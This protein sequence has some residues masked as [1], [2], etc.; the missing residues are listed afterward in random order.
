M[1]RPQ[2]LA[3]PA[4][5]RAEIRATL[6]LAWPLILGNFAQAAINTT[7]VLILGRYDTDALAAS[8]LAVNLYFAFGVFAMGL[9]TAASP[10]IAAE[11]GRRFNSVRDVRRTVRQAL[12]ASITIC[13]PIWL[14]LWF[15]EPI[16][17]ALGQE[18]A[19]ADMAGHFLR[20][21][22]WGLLP[23][24]G[25]VVL[26]YYVSALER[27]IWG[28]I[29]TS[30]GVAFNALICWALVYGRLGLPEMGLTGAAV[31]NVCAYLFLL[32]GMVAVTRWVRPFRRYRLFGHFW[33]ADWPRYRE[34]FRLGLPI[35]ITLALEVT[36]FNAAVFLMGLIGRDEIAAHAV[37]IQI[38]SLAFMVPFGLSQAATV[39]VGLAHGRRDA[40]GVA[41]A[42]WVALGLGIGA[43]F[44][45]SSA[46]AL[47]PETVIGL[48]IDAADPVNARVFELAVSFLLVAAIFQL[49]DGTQAV[50]A[51]VLRGLQDTRW[52]MIFAACGYW[53]VGMG[54]ALWLGFL[55]GLAG[56]GIWIGLA[57]GLAVVALM[58]L[59]RWTL[60]G[61]FGLTGYAPAPPA[62]APA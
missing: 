5:V 11:R 51:G 41:R 6:A 13:V 4:P 31:A 55:T 2:P 23:Y 44:V 26:R 30:G 10:L 24:L 36:V 3:G 47:F 48:F 15:S 18:P 52:P 37:A 53:L 34:I 16:L 7:D 46:M 32:A 20:V 22:M 45:N 21:A 35:A 28:L 33:R 54:V 50:G 25:Y 12:W 14:T 49:A 61:R 1:P 62:L 29:V 17:L 57:A 27:P 19:L 38:A 39:R 42:G 8:A 40:A 9:V 59:A 58:M 43:A 60:R 56:L